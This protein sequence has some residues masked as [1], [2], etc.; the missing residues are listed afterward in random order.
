MRARAA[1]CNASATVDPAAD[2]AMTG[3]FNGLFYY[4]REG[5][6]IRLV[7]PARTGDVLRTCLAA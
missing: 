7:L 1:A 4:A 5:Q 6:P 2:V 3:A